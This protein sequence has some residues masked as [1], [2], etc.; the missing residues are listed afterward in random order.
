MT[1]QDTSRLLIFSDEV[2]ALV[3]YSAQQLRRLEENG[4]FPRRFRIGKNR[5]AWLRG[6]VEQWLNDRL[7]ER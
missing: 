7:G 4:Q 3:H 1:T 5:I 6:E 2:Y